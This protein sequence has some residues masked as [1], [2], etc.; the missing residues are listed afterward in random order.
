MHSQILVQEKES[1]DRIRGIILN[2][3]IHET[4]QFILFIP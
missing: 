2:L 1:A 4:F 3:L